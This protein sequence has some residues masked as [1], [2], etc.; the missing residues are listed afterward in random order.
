[1]KHP[2]K[3][4]FE[5]GQNFA[6]RQRIIRVFWESLEFFIRPDPLLC[7]NRYWHVKANVAEK[8]LRSNATQ[9]QCSMLRESAAQGKR[10]F[11]LYCLQFTVNF[12][13]FFI[14]LDSLT[15]VQFD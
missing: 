15:W 5:T 11:I 12:Y 6:S 1:M 3:T 14:G 9:Q 2:V 8:G 4:A 10:H 13:L 7:R